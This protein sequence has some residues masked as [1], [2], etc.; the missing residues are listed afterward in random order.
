M[1]NEEENNYWQMCQIEDPIDLKVR[2]IDRVFDYTKFKGYR[3]DIESMDEKPIEYDSSIDLHA[4][5]NTDQK[6]DLDKKELLHNIM[7][8]YI[9]VSEWLGDGC[10]EYGSHNGYVSRKMSLAWLFD[11]IRA[12]INF[13][14]DN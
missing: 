2:D 11:A 12:L 7:K 1:G 10:T 6:V 3:N 13:K 14:M 4:K 5:R 8:S 9:E